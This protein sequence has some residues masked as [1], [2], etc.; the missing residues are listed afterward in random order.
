MESVLE[1]IEASKRKVYEK[2]NKKDNNFKIKTLA[3]RESNKSHQ[4][5]GA[6]P[7]D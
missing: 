3:A 4:L 7:L 6:A 2:S 5:C 1:E